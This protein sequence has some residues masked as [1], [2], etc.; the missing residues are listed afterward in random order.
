[1]SIIHKILNSPLAIRKG[2]GIYRV[3]PETGE[4]VF[5]GM[6]RPEMTHSEGNPLK[7][8]F[9]L[10]LHAHLGDRTPHGN[11][12]IGPHG[13]M[14]W[15]DQF[16][17]HH[18]HGIDGVANMLGKIGVKDPAAMINE[19]I[20]ITNEN[21]TLGEK[22]HM[23]GFNDPAWR[24]L[25]YHQYNPSHTVENAYSYPYNGGK[26][27]LATINLSSAA[28]VTA[29]G[30]PLDQHPESYRIGFAP[31]LRTLIEAAGLQ[32]PKF[33]E[34]ITHSYISGRFLSDDPS[35]KYQQPVKR[36]RAKYGEKLNPDNTLSHEHAQHIGAT[37]NT[38]APFQDDVHTWEMMPVLPKI[39]NH[40]ALMQ[41]YKETQGK[42]GGGKKAKHTIYTKYLTEMAD[43]M[44][45]NTDPEVLDT[46]LIGANPPITLRS[47]LESDVDRN[48]LV[49]SMMQS[50][51]ALSFLLGNPENEG[52]AK[53]ILGHME[54]KM[55]AGLDPEG[56]AAYQNALEGVT[57]GKTQHTQDKH[58]HNLAAR[59]FAMAHIV[60]PEELANFS[61]GEMPE[62]EQELVEQQNRIF[63]VVAH[64]LSQAHGHQPNR[65]LTAMDEIPAY[66]QVT[67]PKGLE[68]V[69][70][71]GDLPQ[72]ITENMV[73]Q[74][75][76][77]PQ[78]VVQAEGV[79]DEADAHKEMWQK[80]GDMT[81]EQ[82]QKIY[83]IAQRG[84]PERNIPAPVLAERPERE[85]S[86]FAQNQ[87]VAQEMTHPETGMPLNE[88]E[89][90]ARFF[91]TMRQQTNST[92]TR[93]T[94]PRFQSPEN[95]PIATSFDTVSVEDRIIK[96][97]ERM[98]M[99]DAKQDMAV[100]SQ[101][102]TVPLNRESEDD[103]S[104]LAMKMGIT[105]QDV[106][107]IAHSKGDWHRIA[108]AYDIKPIVVKAVKVSLEAE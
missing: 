105:K 37:K 57:G 56:M 46:P 8:G 42:G 1:M 36:L 13:D 4:P 53:W 30:Q 52:P 14:V 90:M 38:V 73:Q 87:R 79:P 70:T 76:Q 75:E 6:P 68:G 3:D 20:K 104:F 74:I 81:Q 40:P 47:A 23:P 16:G 51:G 26:G 25:R 61:M 2:E 101:A 82:R 99:L 11:W 35:G 9:D 92:Q 83:D 66:N 93:I 50:P 106:R 28:K 48:S 72:H 103:L 34:G 31:V 7:Y 59:L 89:V 17:H 64:S 80:T 22:A 63:D 94:D 18:R 107:G 49:A 21:H 58:G 15:E 19:A 96:A 88:Q 69:M 100:L 98:Q 44:L 39:L 33:M 108:K 91:N 43:Q 55:L 24:K 97:M 54:E 71:G 10:P 32:V 27:T 67:M 12:K 77:L 95:P 60:D 45:A 85:L 78:P 29:S 65:A 41:H 86:A 102:I 62:A 5:I 84:Y